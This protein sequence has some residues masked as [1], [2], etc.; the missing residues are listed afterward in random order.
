MLQQK[1]RLGSTPKDTVSLVFKVTFRPVLGSQI[2][3]TWLAGSAFV[4]L[5]MSKSRKINSELLTFLCVISALT[6]LG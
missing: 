1:Q 6:K 3:I 4:K 2:L 5:G